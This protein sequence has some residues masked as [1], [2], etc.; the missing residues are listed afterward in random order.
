[1]LF[2]PLTL[3]PATLI[4]AAM[5]AAPCYAA[6][7]G[8]RCCCLYG[9]QQDADAACYFTLTPMPADYT[10][11]AALHVAAIDAPLLRAEVIA[12]LIN[13]YTV[14]RSGS[15]GRYA[16]LLAAHYATFDISPISA[17]AVSCRFLRLPPL[18]AITPPCC[19]RDTPYAMVRH[20]YAITPLI[21]M[22]MPA[23]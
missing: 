23:A 20:D 17:S 22:L 7:R 2:S 18:P 10:Y 13:E 3:M 16:S 5:P 12:I 14:A 19:L 1:M 15:S 6:M 4:F 8:A 11:A 21:S 9:A